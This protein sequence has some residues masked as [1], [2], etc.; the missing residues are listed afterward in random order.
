MQLLYRKNYCSRSETRRSFRITS[1][2]ISDTAA[3]TK[4]PKNADQNPSTTKFSSNC[5]ATHAVK[6]SSA[7]LTNKTKK[8]NVAAIKQHEAS[9][10]MGFSTTFTIAN[11]A[12]PASHDCQSLISI[13]LTITLATNNPRPLTKNRNNNND[14]DRSIGS[15]NR[16]R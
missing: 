1:V 5:P 12:V 15:P 7:V 14:G 4:A 11:I 16:N 2:S 13:P 6:P 3:M 8:P 10:A 9:I